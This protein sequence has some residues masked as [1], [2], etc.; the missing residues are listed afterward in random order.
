MNDMI[1]TL[2]RLI[3]LAHSWAQLIPENLIALVMRFGVGVIFFRSGLLKVEGFSITSSTYALFANEYQ[4]PLLPSRLAAQLATTA[5]LTLPLLLFAGLAA[6]LG[7]L[8]LLG[9]TLVIQLFVY[10]QAWQIHLGWAAMLLYL[11][12]RGAGGWSLDRLI[13][14]R[15]AQS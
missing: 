7:A 1:Q 4:V 15:F 2:R 11:I 14:A 8:G 3:A 10:P 13:Q 6:R 12:G 5:E 9:M